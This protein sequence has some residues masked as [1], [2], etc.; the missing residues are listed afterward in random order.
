MPNRSDTLYMVKQRLI[1][2]EK[3]E[4]EVNN[5]ICDKK[6]KFVTC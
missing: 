5:D 6:M 3:K 1:G 2:L 4:K